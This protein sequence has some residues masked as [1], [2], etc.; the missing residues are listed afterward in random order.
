[1]WIWEET[2]IKLLLA[3]KSKELITESS[4]T[5]LNAI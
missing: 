5:K 4:K 1:M 3:R 2:I